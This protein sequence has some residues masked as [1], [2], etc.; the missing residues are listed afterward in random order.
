MSSLSRISVEDLSTKDFL[1]SE[2]K[3]IIDAIKVLNKN[4]KLFMCYQKM[5]L[6]CVDQ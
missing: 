5:I 2:D 4:K 3:K 6:S 1:I